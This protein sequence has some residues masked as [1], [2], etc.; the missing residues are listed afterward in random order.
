[1]KSQ[2]IFVALVALCLA[3]SVMATEPA[4]RQHAA[5]SV[6]QRSSCGNPGG[7]LD[8]YYGTRL[9][10]HRRTTNINNGGCYTVHSDHDWTT[11][12]LQFKDNDCSAAGTK[13]TIYRDDYCSNLLLTIESCWFNSVAIPYLAD[14]S[15]DNQMNSY[16]IVTAH[17]CTNGKIVE[18]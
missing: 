18:Y 13:L 12:S 15:A 4:P 5:K 3:S 10:G 1:M 11:S 7:V 6:S 9:N 16:K 14:Y 17:S 2:I 8:Y